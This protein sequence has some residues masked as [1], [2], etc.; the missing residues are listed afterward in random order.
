MAASQSMSNGSIFAAAI[1]ASQSMI[2]KGPL[3][4]LGFYRL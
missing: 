1:A 3:Q 2:S 4:M